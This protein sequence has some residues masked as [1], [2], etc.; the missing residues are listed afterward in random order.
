MTVRCRFAPAPSGSMHV[1]NART[2]LFSWLFARH[3]GGT[4]ILRIEDTD[5]SRVTDEAIDILIASL[6][7]LGLD[8]DEGPES[9]GPHHPYRQTERMDIYRQT[10][11]NLLEQ[12]DAYRCYC[13]Q[14]ELK[15]RREKAMAEGRSP[16]YDGRCRTLT[17]TER[18]E[19][20]DA[21]RPYVLRF[22]MPK[23]KAYTVHDLVR[24]EVAFAPGT[25]RDYVLMRSDGSPTYMLAAPVDDY[26]ME[27]THVIRGEDLL[28]STPGQ[29]ALMEAIGA[30]S[31]PTYAHLPLIVGPDR[32][33]L[34]KRHGS[35]SVEAFREQGY[36]PEALLNYLALLGWSKDES[37][38]FLSRD[39][40]VEHFDLSRVSHN[41]AAFDTEKLEWLNG[42]YIQNTPVEDLA[43]RL[44]PSF[45]E[46][47]IAVDLE[48]LQRAVPL[49]NERMK[50][51]PD[52][53]ELLRFLFTDDIS[54]NEK[55][56][57]IL[58][59]APD[60]YLVAAADALGSL[61]DWTHEA[62]AAALDALAEG[63]GLNRTK[64]WQPV[65]AAVTGSNI[66]PPLP[67]SL[68]LLGRD[69]TVSRL[70]ALAD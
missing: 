41:P 63:A 26:L 34:S 67:E 17:D 52:A 57:G 31:L 22:A 33:P 39:E 29:I 66:S 21:G 10:A 36:L 28:P 19:N 44:L 40:L 61:E 9:G 7:W 27:M 13:T 46:A 64:G 68:E 38:T 47:G 24:G 37:T 23:D 53:V 69:A 65:R 3:N 51:L 15:E 14:E 49:I 58:A 4:F 62:I 12:G 48:L 35:V 8:W 6:R 55:A 20:E 1:G 16:G 25:T 42:H 70:R 56:A 50:L 54:P 11:A 45:G 5:A 18:S 30:T 32:Q 2:G 59:K 43:A 60:G